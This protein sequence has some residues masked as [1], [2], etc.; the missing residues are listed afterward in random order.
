MNVS[1]R[2]LL[3]AAP[4]AA[5]IPVLAAAGCAGTV[6]TT[7]AVDAISSDIQLVV[8]GLTAADADPAIQADLGAASQKVVAAALADA[9]TVVLDLKAAGDTVSLAT[10]QGWAQEIQSDA[11]AVIGLVSV[12]PGLPASTT[13]YIVAVQVLLPIILS[14]VQSV[15]ASSA[16]RGAPT[17]M[18]PAQARA[19]LAAL[20]K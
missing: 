12:I 1:R 9:N 2:S 10:G 3:K 17:T 11:N 13:G 18:T 16:R 5:A 14:T 15:L 20:K 4:Y 7:V 19:V 6:V 8:A